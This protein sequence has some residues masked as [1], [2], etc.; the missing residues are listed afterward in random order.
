MTPLR[1]ESGAAPEV[2]EVST[3]VAVA[4]PSVHR[5]EAIARE[6]R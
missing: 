5:V 4:P 6:H 3:P 2:R 1:Y